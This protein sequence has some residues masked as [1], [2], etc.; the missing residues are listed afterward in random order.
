MSAQARAILWAQVRSLLNYGRRSGFG[1]AFTAVLF[2]FWYGIF[3][4]LA[5]LAARVMSDPDNGPML[6]RRL[7]GILFGILLYW[8]VVPVAMAAT[9]YALEMRKLLVYPIPHRRLFGIDLLLRALTSFEM[10]I[11]LTGGAIGAAMN[12]RLPRWGLLG[13]ASFA[14]FNLFVASG[15]KEL[16]ARALARRRFRELFTFL[17]VLICALPQLIVVTRS[18]D[19]VTRWFGVISAPVLPWSA[20]AG[21]VQGRQALISLASLAAW[22]AAAYFFGRNQFERTLRFDADA[23]RASSPGARSRGTGGLDWLFRWPAALFRDPLAALIEKELRF[24]SRAPRFRLVFVM[25]FSFGLLIWIPV[26]MNNRGG[27]MA[28]NFLVVVSAYALLMLGDVCFWNTF[29]FDRSAVQVYLTAPVRFQA[30]LVAK[31]IAAFFFILLEV[32]SISL[33][34]AVIRLPV[35]PVRILEAVSV[36]AVLSLYLMGVGNLTSTHSP[37]AMNP[38]KATRSGAAAKSQFLLMFLFPVAAIP[39]ALAYVARWAF[40]SE[41][42]F[43][44]TL[45]VTGAVGA[46]LYR[47]ALDSAV[48]AV[49]QRREQFVTALSQGEGPIG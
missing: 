21:F 35:G 27:F 22:V 4:A 16:L 18:E 37:R 43:F 8:Q 23:A 39:I 33:V 41:P 3:T 29:G 25:G 10:F 20:T 47:V 40:R 49:R 46:C 5:V 31:N 44:L 36:T 1:V 7:P 24:L 11:L 38:Q 14:A 48:S 2:F 42:A 34:C 26:L 32:V 17:F 12:P 28:R 13:F 19:R 15:I 30:V 6:A 9:G 45:L